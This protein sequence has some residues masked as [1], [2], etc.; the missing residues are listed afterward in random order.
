MKEKEVTSLCLKAESAKTMLT[1]AEKQFRM[2]L[3]G[4]FAAAS[5]LEVKMETAKEKV[6]EAEKNYDQAYDEYYTM[7]NAYIVALNVYQSEKA[8]ADAK[9]EAKAAAEAKVA[10]YKN[11]LAEMRA[12][13]ADAK[14]LKKIAV[15]L[16]EYEEA[17]TTFSGAAAA[18]GVE[19]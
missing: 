7:W 14:D 15:L 4:S 19:W 1:V 10:D 18:L 6:A 5:A 12:E 2:S 8:A 9:E 11:V 3:G 16:N 13:L 17:E